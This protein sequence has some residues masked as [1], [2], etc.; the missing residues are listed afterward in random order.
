[1]SSRVSC[2]TSEPHRSFVPLRFQC[3]PFEV[4][5]ILYGFRTNPRMACILARGR[6]LRSAAR[7]VTVDRV[8]VGT[9]LGREPRGGTRRKHL[10]ITEDV[11]T[12]DRRQP[13]KVRACE[14]LHVASAVDQQPVLLEVG[15]V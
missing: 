3:R 14:S 5:F 4:P 6:R 7:L 13:T 12:I 2:M 10:G 9:P 8:W 1:M 15:C 11:W